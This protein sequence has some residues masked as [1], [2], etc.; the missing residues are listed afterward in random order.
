MDLS[1]L[2]EDVKDIPMDADGPNDSGG[3]LND[4][5]DQSDM[6]NHSETK[7]HPKLEPET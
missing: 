7:K 5:N 1:D 2:D 4:P 3:G 6:Q